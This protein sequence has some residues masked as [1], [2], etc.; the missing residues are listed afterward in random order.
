MSDFLTIKPFTSDMSFY[1]FQDLCS[2]RR[3]PH[4]IHQKPDFVALAQGLNRSAVYLT[5][6]LQFWLRGNASRM[7]RRLQ[8]GFQTRRQ[9]YSRV[10]ILYWP[11]TA[12]RVRRCC[13][14]FLFWL[15]MGL[16]VPMTSKTDGPYIEY[17]DSNIDQFWSFDT[18]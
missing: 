16:K 9:N 15:Y 1:G 5:P 13:R 3:H 11:W 2:L 12:E 4:Y 14:R 8:R 18:F 6:L 10:R 17:V 7:S